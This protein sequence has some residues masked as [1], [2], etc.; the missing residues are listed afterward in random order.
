MLTERYLLLAQKAVSIVSHSAPKRERKYF[1]YIWRALRLAKS[2]KSG[3]IYN[4]KASTM[5]FY[6]KPCCAM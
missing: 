1:F 2:T 3:Y 5:V 6:A 4:Q